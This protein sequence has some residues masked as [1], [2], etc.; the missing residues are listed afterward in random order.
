MRYL[1]I[2][3]SL[4]MLTAQ[5]VAGQSAAYSPGKFYMGAIAGVN[6]TAI[7][8]Q[9]N[10]GQ[11]EMDYVVPVGFAAG[12][13]MH[14]RLTQK[15]HLIVEVSYQQMG[16][17]HDDHFKDMDFYKDINISYIGIPVLYKL[18]LNKAAVGY[19]AGVN[20]SRPKW[21]LLGGFQ[22]SILVSAKVRHEING[23]QTDFISFIT[24][25]GN[26][27]L[28]E[29]LIN[30]QP[31]DDKE[32]YNNFDISFIGAAGF[33]AHIQPSI[34]GFVELRG[35]IG[36]LDINS[37]PW[38]LPGP[39]GTYNWSRNLFIGLHAGMIFKIF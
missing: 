29:I 21:Y 3:V 5:T 28:E 30:G 34:I 35:G 6:A 9:N 22:P 19:E 26:P 23:S 16:Q 31:S 24:E 32:L 25:G 12:A 8:F 13:A 18:V 4:F 11:T 7:V 36:L 27:N 33:H 17:K 10:Y 20:F 39:S 38:Q 15:S 2:I 1:A 14:Y 37:E